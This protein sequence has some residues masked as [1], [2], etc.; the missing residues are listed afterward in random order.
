MN[1]KKTA[2][3]ALALSALSV[4]LGSPAWSADQT[5]TNAGDNWAQHV[6]RQAAEQ[7]GTPAPRA[8][9]GAAPS[10]AP[11]AMAE[12]GAVIPLGPRAALFGSLAPANTTS[13]A[14]TLA[15]GLKSVNVASGDTVT[16]RSG[17][18]EAT[19]T[20]AEF[21]HGTSVD[22]GVLFPALPNARGVRVYIERSKLYTGG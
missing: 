9:P 4:L 12:A 19:W 14:V 21:V 1:T 17:A 18:Q 22:L 8:V 16:F 20:F 11:R 3:T 2:F 10:A 13:R 7:A 15:P 6:Q 5:R